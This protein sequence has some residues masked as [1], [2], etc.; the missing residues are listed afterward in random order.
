MVRFLATLTAVALLTSPAIAQDASHLTPS[1]LSE[2][3][4]SCAPGSSLRAAQNALAQTDGNRITQNWESIIALDSFFTL[5]LEDQRITDQKETGRCWMFS[6]LNILRP[7][8]ASKLDCDDIELSQNYLYFFEKLERANLFL[9]AII[10]TR[11]KPYTDRTV[12]FLLKTNAADGNNWVGFVELVEKYGVVPKD[13][14]PETYSSSHSGHVINVLGLRLKQAAMKIRHTTTPDSI[15]TFKMEALKD[16]YRILAINFG[17]PPKE[18]EWRYMKS[19]TVLSPLKTYTPPQF[20]Q[21]MIGDALDDYYPLY[22]IP[23]LPFER[24]YEIEYDRTVSDQPNMYFVNCPLEMLKEIAKRSLLDSTAVWFGCDVSRE[25]SFDVGVMIPGL[26]DIQSLYGIDIAFTRED[27]FETYSSI[28][29]HNMVF[30]GID[31]VD[32]KVKKWLVENSWG[33]TKGKAGF[34]FMR[35]DWFDQYVQMVVLRKEYIPREVLALFDTKA[36][37]LPPWDPMATP[38][39]IK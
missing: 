17:L 21:E 6:G 3:E 10:L 15:P 39:R 36:E 19:D 13:V 18:F 31:I 35:D 12:E 37:V 11:D 20:F 33:D 23:T 24:K 32:G 27:L 25:S 14:M 5:R 1:V 7:I 30:S 26:Y 29:T 22:S 9:E 28:P 38:I 16:V 2:L 8:V 4:Q 34:Y